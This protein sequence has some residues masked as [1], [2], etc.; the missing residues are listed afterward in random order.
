[1]SDE[2]ATQLDGR[3]A[4]AYREG[5]TPPW[6]AARHNPQIIPTGAPIEQWGIEA[7]LN[8]RVQVI[9]NHRADGTPIDESYYIERT[10]NNHKTGPYIAGAW[11]PVQNSTILK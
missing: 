1:M 2:L 8:Y 3:I 9:P 7:G 11:Q 6:H 4:M 5:A 10:D